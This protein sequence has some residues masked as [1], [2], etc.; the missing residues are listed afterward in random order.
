[1]TFALM[2]LANHPAQLDKLRNQVA[3]ILG[4]RQE[5]EWR[6]LSKLDFTEAVIKESLRLYPP[7]FGIPKVT[8]KNAVLN[9]IKVPKG[10]RII[11]N[12]RCMQRDPRYWKSPNEWLPERWT[13]DFVSVM[14]SYLPF[15]D[16]PTVCKYFF[17]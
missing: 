14:G 6:D 16:G 4:D 12:N 10:T 11:L 13:S 5:L 9:S 3:Q 17:I 2:E 7:A 8:G 1:M 15:S